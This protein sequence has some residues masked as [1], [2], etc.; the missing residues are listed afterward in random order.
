MFDRYF[1]ALNSNEII[2]DCTN[3]CFL[4]TSLKRLPAEAFRQSTSEGP[5]AVEKAFSADVIRREHQMILIIMDIFSSF[6]QGALISN[7]QHETLQR[8]LIQLS[9][10]YK[11]SEGCTIRVDNASGFVR[12][13]NDRL[14]AS[15]GINLDFGRVKNKNKNPTVDRSIQDV[16]SEVKRLS[17]EGGQISPGTLAIAISYVNSQIRDSDLRENC[18][19]FLKRKNSISFRLSG[20]VNHMFLQVPIY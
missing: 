6:L 13:R 8:G 4:C 20:F 1:F 19:E 18:G 16:E 5:D 10:D 17:P 15:V 14:L 3:S 9:A 2:D 7:E 11:H 12:L